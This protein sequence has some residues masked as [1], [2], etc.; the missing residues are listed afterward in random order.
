MIE[1]NFVKYKNRGGLVKATPSVIIVCEETEKCFQRLLKLLGGNLQHEAGI[2]DAV[3]MAVLRA[4][5][6]KKVFTVLENQMLD[7]PATGNHIFSLIKIA[8]LCYCKIRLHHLGKVLNA[9]TCEKNI[10]KQLTKL[11]LFKHR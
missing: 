4:V 9:N 7:L 8:S 6:V 2:P 3:A 10:R 11:F 1:H 5:D